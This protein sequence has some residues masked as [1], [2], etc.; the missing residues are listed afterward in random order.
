MNVEAGNDIKEISATIQA[1]NGIN[2][3]LRNELADI[4][5]Q[6]KQLYDETVMELMLRMVEK[7][8]TFCDNQM[9]YAFNMAM[10]ENEDIL[11]SKLWLQIRQTVSEIVQKGTKIDW[12]WLKVCLLPS[13]IWYKDISAKDSD[14]PHYLFYELLKMVNVEAMNQINELEANIDGMA[15]KQK[16]DWNALIKW[17]IPNEYESARQDLI[18]NGIASRFTFDQLSAS[19][20]TTFN[21][22]QFYDYNQYLSQLVLLAQIVDEEFQLSVQDIFGIDKVT[23]KGMVSAKAFGQNDDEKEVL[24]N[25]IVEYMR[26]PIKLMERARAKAQNDYAKEPYPASACVIDFNRCALIFDDISSL[27]RGLKLFVNKVKYYQSG[28]IIAIARDKNGFIE[29][30]KEAQY[31][32]IKLNVVIKGRHNSIIG[33]VQFL[34]R[35]MKDYKDKAHN[36]YAIQR[37]EEMMKGSVSKILPILLDQKK[38]IVGVA[39]EGKVKKMCSLMIL[40]NQSIKDVMFVGETGAGGATVLSNVF[41]FGHYKMMLFLKSMVSRKEF[42]DNALLSNNYD[43]KPIEYAINN[44][45]SAV[46]KYLLDMEEIRAEYQDNDPMIFRILYALFCENSDED[47]TKYVLSVL[48]IDKKKINQMLSYK[49]PRQPKGDADFAYKFHK[50]NILCELVWDSTFNHLKRFV[51]VVGIELIANNIF[52]KDG[53]NWDAMGYALMYKKI[54]VIEYLLSFEVVRQKY[55]SNNERLRGLIRDMNRFIDHKDT[56]Q[57]AVTSLGLTE[58]RLEEL[59]SFYSYLDIS[60]VAKFTKSE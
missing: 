45:R 28:N 56:I 36:L 50:Y 6:S 30:V 12:M 38:D 51:S 40:Q 52:A 23:N 2:D 43:M 34:L 39:C 4:G 54:K 57:C 8:R 25:G 33:E 24:G 59:K 42:V 18:V 53:L 15:S 9:I 37:K 14:E 16:N 58:A 46:V 1:Q 10:T 32:D 41:A 3:C 20:G 49:C 13:M 22:P 19:S 7:R 44:S 5:K 17:N 60:K 48:N 26:G 31:A 11:T 29:Y 27:L 35:A 55:L 21:S 47:L